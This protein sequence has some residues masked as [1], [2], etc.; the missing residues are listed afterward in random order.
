MFSE[1]RITA[2]ERYKEVMDE[3]EKHSNLREEFE[4]VE[5][6]GTEDFRERIR[7][8]IRGDKKKPLDDILR[9]ACPRE[10]DYKLI[11]KGS[12]K[13]YL[14]EFKYEYIK[15]SIEEGYSTAE[16][17]ENLNMTRSG[18]NNLSR[19]CQAPK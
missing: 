14:T 16:I 12:R 1:D 13:R 11:K 10:V 15:M 17:A 9:I 2:I 4:I 7:L 19:S 6:I 3:E 18:V 8:E 5:I